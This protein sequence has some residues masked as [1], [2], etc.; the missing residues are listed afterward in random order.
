MS[1]PVIIILGVPGSGK[2]TQG[3]NIASKFA[4]Q[5]LAVGDLV[6]WIRSKAE[7]GDKFAMQVKERYDRGIPQPDSAIYQILRNKLS[8]LNLESGIVLD[9][10]PLSLG[11]A[12]EL[13]RIVTEY[14]LD[15]P[16][17]LFLHIDGWE[18]VRRISR[19]KFCPKCSVAYNPGSDAYKNG[20]CLTDKSKLVT[21][22][23]DNFFAVRTRMQ[24]YS[25][26][27][28]HIHKYLK[29]KGVEVDINGQ[30][31]IDEVFADILKELAKRGVR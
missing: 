7:T 2:G 14:N 27:M 4:M 6:R 3:R 22:D 13:F 31:T 5:Y 15:K 24:E 28:D 21:R 23:D 8:E 11:Q 9:S 16:I 26:R 20:E 25:C 30:Q 1:K 17:V 18:S 10:F 19:R 12:Q 29:L